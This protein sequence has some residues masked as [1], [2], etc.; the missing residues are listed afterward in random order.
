MQSQEIM[1]GKNWRKVLEEERNTAATIHAHGEQATASDKEAV[2]EEYY[3]PACTEVERILACD[4]S[5]MDMS[6]Y[7]KQRALNILRDQKQ[8]KEKESNTIKRWNS[9]DGLSDLLREIPWDPEDNVRYVVKW[10][11]LPFAEMTWEYWRDIKRDVVDEA[12]DFWIRQ[13]P[14][15]Q[16]VIDRNNR[17]HPQIRD[18]RKIQESPVFGLSSRKREVADLGQDK[19]GDGDEEK[20]GFRLRSYQLEGVNWLMFNWWNKRSCILADEMG[21]GKVR[22]S[23]IHVQLKLH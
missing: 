8:L 10:K 14:P 13:Q 3:P 1:Y 18:F 5:E 15:P 12:E 4:E 20:Q 16:D 9:K 17:A 7:A 6:L 21:L 22:F 23:R 19:D 2:E 11:G